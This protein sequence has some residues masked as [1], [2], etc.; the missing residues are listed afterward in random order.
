MSARL[1]QIYSE[2]REETPV[3]PAW[4]WPAMKANESANSA[5]RRPRLGRGEACL[6]RLR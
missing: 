5:K 2:V 6:A 3:W 1:K 4:E